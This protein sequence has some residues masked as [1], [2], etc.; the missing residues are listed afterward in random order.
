MLNIENPDNNLD[1]IS[2]KAI[3][4]IGY[5]RDINMLA[6]IASS[7]Q[8]HI[9]TRVSAIEALRKFPC[10]QLEAIEHIY[11]MFLDNQED[12][13]IRINSF[14]LIM[15]CSSESQ[16]FE[17]FTQSKLDDF[18]LNEKDVQVIHG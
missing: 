14:L 4:N 11:S 7:K 12:T 9:A 2:L 6:N 16:R 8:Q 15:R 13:E 5:I 1:V 17:Q 10:D 18:L 3:G